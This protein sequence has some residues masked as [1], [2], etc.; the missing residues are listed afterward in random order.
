[1]VCRPWRLKIFQI[2]HSPW[3]V[4]VLCHIQMGVNFHRRSDAGMADALAECGKVKI[5]II[6]VVQI[7]VSHIGMSEAMHRDRMRKANSLA[8]LSVCL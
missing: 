4:A 2:F 7:I 6:L 1:M 8:N 5:R 3:N